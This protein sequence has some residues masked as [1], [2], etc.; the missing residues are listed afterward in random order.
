MQLEKPIFLTKL[1]FIRVLVFHE[2]KGAANN[3]ATHS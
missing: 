2:W 3:R 1:F